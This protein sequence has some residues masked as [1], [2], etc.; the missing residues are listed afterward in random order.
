MKHL[1]LLLAVFPLFIAAQH[2]RP[3]RVEFEGEDSDREYRSQLMEKEGVAVYYPT[4]TTAPDS[5][6]WAVVM[7]DTNLVM[8]SVAQF[9]LPPTAE[10]WLSDYNN[11][12]VYLL[13]YCDKYKKEEPKWILVSYHDKNKELTKIELPLPFKSAHKMEIENEYLA[14]ET[15]ESKI[16]DFAI[17]NL[18]NNTLQFL[19]SKNCT[20]DSFW[21]EFFQFDSSKEHLLIGLDLVVDVDNKLYQAMNLL[22]VYLPTNEYKYAA[23]PETG[24]TGF[25]TARMFTVNNNNYLIA[26]TYNSDGRKKSNVKQTGIYAIPFH[27][28]KSGNGPYVVNASAPVYNSFEDI[29]LRYKGDRGLE[30]RTFNAMVGY[31]MQVGEPFGY[32]GKYS[33][34]LELYYH[35]YYTDGYG[36]S[37]FSGYKFGTA[38]VATF[39]ADGKLETATPFPMNVATSRVL[40]S[41]T[42]VYTDPQQQQIIYSVDYTQ[43]HSMVIKD[44]E[45]IVPFESHDMIKL[46]ESDKIMSIPVGN[47]PASKITH[48]YNNCFIITGYQK[49]RNK[50]YKG[51]K[52][53]RWVYYISKVD[54]R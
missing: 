9:Q 26:G 48:W 52:E 21:V 49:I 8:G 6:A 38:Y 42:S 2:D 37:Q 39:A 22:D 44:N 53:K 47:T 17:C 15:R 54:Y 13:F 33:L 35:D 5:S 20:S 23:F 40:H 14:I 34:P 11:G 43:I 24:E 4:A 46:Y 10:A 12:K 3:L 7:Y 27:L 32:N 50:L 18:K 28:E 45:I 16:N 25:V 51:D 41:Y 30:I 31:N 29:S 1:F 36:R 19:L